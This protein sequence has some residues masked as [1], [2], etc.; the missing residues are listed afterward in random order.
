VSGF[1]RVVVA[2][3]RH[4][5]VAKTFTGT[6]PGRSVAH[7]FVAGDDLGRAIPVAANLNRKGLTVSLDLLGEEVHDAATALAALDGYLA[8]IGRIGSDGIDANVSVKLTQL[9]L[10]FDPGLAADAVDH[11]AEAAKSAGTSV[12]IDMEDSRF[13]E[14]TVDIYASAQQRHGNLGVCLQ[15]YLKRTPDDLERLLPIGGHI[16]LCKGAYVEPESV[17]LQ[18]RERVDGAFRDLLGRLMAAESVKPAIATHDSALIDLAKDLGRGRTSPWEFQ[19]LY[20]V[21]A[22][23]QTSLAAEGHAMRIYVPF[24][25][26]WYPY[27]TRRLAERPANVLFFLRALVGRD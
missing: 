8:S 14:Q 18:G 5:I 24:G 7:R 19:M 10:A 12:T 4:P 11:L 2:A 3:T 6:R 27:L 25:S 1:S 23:L 9:G 17:A 16:R 22:A 21:R 20:G 13:T 26:E 15:A